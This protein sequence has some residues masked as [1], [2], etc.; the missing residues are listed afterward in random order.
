M[1]R[2]ASAFLLVILPAMSAFAQGTVDLPEGMALSEKPVPYVS[3]NQDFQLTFP[4]GCGELHSRVNEPDLFGGETYDD[5]VNVQYTYCDRH[6]E[7]GEGCSITAVFNW[8]DSEGN[9][10]GPAQ[11]VS[12]THLTL[13]TTPY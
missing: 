8:H 12:Y 7:K 13:P 9:P 11:A 3:P 2:I 5:I 1:M 10:A 6:Q 4:S